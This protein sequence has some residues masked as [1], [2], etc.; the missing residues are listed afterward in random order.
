MTT[1]IDL[2]T[3]PLARQRA[4]VFERLDA[5][6][7][8][9]ALSIIDDH[10]PMP[11]YFRLDRARNGQFGWRYLQTGPACWQVRI[12]RIGTRPDRAQS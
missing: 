12:E 4:L 2:R 5:L 1:D 9:E 10:D 8:G 11:L 7:T 3:V 6:A